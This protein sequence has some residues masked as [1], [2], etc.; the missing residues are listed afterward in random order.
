[1]DDWSSIAGQIASFKAELVHDENSRRVDVAPAAPPLEDSQEPMANPGAAPPSKARLCGV[2]GLSLVVLGLFYVCLMLSQV[3]LMLSF[4]VLSV[5]LC[6]FCC[7]L[8]D[9]WPS[10]PY[11]LF[12]VQAHW[13][14]VDEILQTMEKV[15]KES[16]KCYDAILQAS[17]GP[18]GPS[19]A[20][21]G[22]MTQ[23][24]D[25]YNVLL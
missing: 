24:E 5:S 21:N 10:G 4:M 13:N 22:L 18:R 20:K 23:M 16:N 14:A 6:V 25:L 19:V 17:D 15:G 9:I 1:L 3:L 7:L 11:L 2:L 12:Q 8:C